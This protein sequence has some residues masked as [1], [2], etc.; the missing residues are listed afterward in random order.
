M[1]EVLGAPEST[2]QGQLLAVEPEGVTMTVSSGTLQE[3]F[4]F[5]SMHQEMTV[6]REQILV[7]ER[8]RLDPL[9]TVGVAALGAVIAGFV[10][11][12][13]FEENQDQRAPTPPSGPGELR[14]PLV[15]L[16]L[17]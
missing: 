3:G 16:R 14:A 8:R 17:P 7:L 11:R 10:I 13:V 2:I 9:R 15:W 12:E 1:N 6:P 5:Q 4:H